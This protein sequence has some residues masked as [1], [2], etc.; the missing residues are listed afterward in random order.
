MYTVLKDT[1]EQHG[2]DFRSSKNCS[3]MECVTLPTGDYSLAGYEHIFTIERKGSTGEFA[4]NVLEKRFDNELERLEFF[5]YPFIIL[6]FD[7]KD[8]LNFPVGSGIPPKLWPNLKMNPFF[9]LK[10]LVDFQMKYKTKIILA[11]K[12]GQDV[13]SSIFK[14]IIEHTNEKDEGQARTSRVV[15][16]RVPRS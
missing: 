8:I 9:L 3:G 10:R 14:R 6:E 13:A 15:R 16:R 1:R 12:N 4:Q 5:Q 11:G 2:W 7:M